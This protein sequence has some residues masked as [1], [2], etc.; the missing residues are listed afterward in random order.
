MC[1]FLH[2]SYQFKL[3]CEFFNAYIDSDYHPMYSCNAENVTTSWN[4]RYVTEISGNHLPGMDN[5][6]VKFLSIFHENCLF[7]PRN[8][9]K[10]FPNLEDLTIRKSN[11]QFLMNGDLDGLN[12]LPTIQLIILEKTSSVDIPQ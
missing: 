12:K 8:L 3:K 5:K 11:I 1:T 9:D 7:I 10:F 4:N 2:S 6:D